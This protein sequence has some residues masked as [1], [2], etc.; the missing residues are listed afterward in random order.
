VS[1]GGRLAAF[2]AIVA[3]AFGA[4]TL[5]GAALNPDVREASEEHEEETM[6]SAAGHEGGATAGAHAQAEGQGHADHGGLPGGLAAAQSGYRIAPLTTIFEPDHDAR[7]RFRILTDAGEPVRDYDVTH[8]RRMHV[9][10]VRRDFTR[11]QHLHPR[12]ADDGAWETEADLSEAGTYRLFADFSTGGQPL[13]LASDL[14]VRGD[15]HPAPLPA[16]ARTASAGDG[17]EV[18][19]RGSEPRTGEPTPL[20]F[21]VR[22][23]GKAVGPVEPYLGADGHLVALREHDQAF[24]HTHPEGEAGGSGPITFE[25][26]YPTPGRYRLYLQFKHEGAVRTAAFTRVV[27]EVG[28]APRAQTGEHPHG[29]TG[30]GH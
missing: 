12:L 26:T 2:A 4:A 29:D 8:E 23:D 17:Y 1:A 7:L 6:D 5:A 10:L 22:R 15:F 25:V 16:P 19:L 13:T 28:A 27:G 30:H 21:D 9:I 24:L 14:F 18:V 20:R 11:F 3:L